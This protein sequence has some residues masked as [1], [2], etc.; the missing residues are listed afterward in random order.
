MLTVPI[1]ARLLSMEIVFEQM[2]PVLKRVSNSVSESPL[3]GA[4]EDFSFYTKETPGLFIFLGITPKDQDP[5]TA[6][7]NHN[8]HFFVDE[9]ALVTGIR[10]MS[11]MAINYLVNAAT[12]TNP[13]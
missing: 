11:S 8:P 1:K 10:A 3:Q 6:A 4:S 12:T 5:A 7:P 9:S 13:K 2:L